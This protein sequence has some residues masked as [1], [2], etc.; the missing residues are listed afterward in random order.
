MISPVKDTCAHVHY[1]LSLLK[2]AC[3]EAVRSAQRPLPPHRLL[4]SGAASRRP[5]RSSGSRQ[6]SPYNPTSSAMLVYALS[7]ITFG[8]SA[9]SRAKMVNRGTP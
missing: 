7:S 1:L 3:R 5:A 9:F 2:R 4:R 8:S 6:R